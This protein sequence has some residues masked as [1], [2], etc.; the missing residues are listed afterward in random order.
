M[1]GNRSETEIMRERERE[2]GRGER[3]SERDH[4]CVCV[5][6]ATPHA[7]YFTNLGAKVQF[8]VRKTEPY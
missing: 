5:H 8:Q 7:R 3:E 2:I 1:K 4:V 6:L